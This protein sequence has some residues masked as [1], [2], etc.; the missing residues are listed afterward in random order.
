MKV[1]LR[2]ERLRYDNLTI[3]PLI[4]KAS[5]SKPVSMKKINLA[6]CKQAPI[7]SVVG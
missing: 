3:S 6:L 5:T 7:I 1:I 2:A 4:K